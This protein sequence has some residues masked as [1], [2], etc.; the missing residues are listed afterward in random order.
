MFEEFD[1]LSED[2]GAEVLPDQY[3]IEYAT[4]ITAR[5]ARMLAPAPI[6]KQALAENMARIEVALL[7]NDRVE[8][9]RLV[10]ERKFIEREWLC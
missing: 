4:V 5:L 2:V 6:K 9:N 8:F 10:T 3:P 7:L 1:C